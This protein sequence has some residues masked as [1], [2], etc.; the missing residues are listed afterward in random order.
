MLAK[1]ATHKA[2]AAYMASIDHGA[3]LHGPAPRPEALL[4]LPEPERAAIAVDVVV[5]RATGPER[6][7]PAWMRTG[8]QLFASV[9]QFPLPTLCAL[10][11]AMSEVRGGV[12]F[13]PWRAAWKHSERHIARHGLAPELY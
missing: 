10:I 7:D 11:H 1:P 2:L 8:G 9:R 5:N 13:F 6:Y 12:C 4:A 3:G